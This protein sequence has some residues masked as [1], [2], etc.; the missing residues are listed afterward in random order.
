LGHL[1]GDELLVAVARRLESCLRLHDY[2]G[3]LGGDEFAILLT[4]VNDQS[5]ANV[6]ALRIQEALRAPLT[7]S[8]RDVFTS[9]S[10][11]IA[12][13]HRAYTTPDEIMRDADTAMYQAK[14]NGKARHELFDMDMHAR[15]RERHDVE[16]DLR[17]AIRK[18]AFDVHYQPIVSL[19][20]GRCI[21]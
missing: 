19:T 9:A 15:A 21:G 7:I 13:V 2:L 18:D 20:S 3:R 8:G 10:I 5:Q 1:I 16:N 14:A 17:H 11:G 6:V 12:F 4:N